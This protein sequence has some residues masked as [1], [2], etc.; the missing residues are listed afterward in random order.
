VV[1]ARAL[2]AKG[3]SPKATKLV[4]EKCIETYLADKLKRGEFRPGTVRRV[5]SF[6]KTFATRS[7]AASPSA[8]RLADLQAYYD[9]RRKSSEAG[10][11]STLAA[12]QG[13]LGDMGCLPG[14]VRLM[15]GSKPE[16][17]RVIVDITTA[18]SWIKACQR[19]DLRFVLFCGF[20]AGM[21]AG[22]IVHSRAEWFDLRRGVIAIPGAE[23]QRLP[24]GQRR[25]W[26]TK[27]GDGREIPISSGFAEFLKTFLPEVRDHCLPSRL[28]SSDGLWDFRLPFRKLMNEVGRPDF[29]PHAMRHSWITHLVN[30]GNHLMQ[31]VS[32]WSGDRLETIESNYWKRKT[33]AGA[34]DK[35]MAGVRSVETLE[36]LE[37]R[38]EELVKA[39]TI[40][41]KAAK[42]I[43]KGFESEEEYMGMN[44]RWAAEDDLLR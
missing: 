30:S 26:R 25:Q 6:L 27:N 3:S 31:E 20:H 34:L 9:D 1:K 11:R 18:N 36:R 37:Q 17:R 2:R 13:F 22:E 24:T 29:F 28:K 8:V 19:T 42:E 35:T 5:R 4:W 23:N 15:A 38:I 10:A 7:G 32:A 39:G 40:K 41:P 33:V 16:A 21:R 44:E 43:W 14:R 12:I